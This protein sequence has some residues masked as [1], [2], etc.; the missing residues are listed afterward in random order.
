MNG[1][2][3]EGHVAASAHVTRAMMEHKLDSKLQRIDLDLD[4][5]T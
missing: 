5:E 1:P 4:L 3:Q 2:D